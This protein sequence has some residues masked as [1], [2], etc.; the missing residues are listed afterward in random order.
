MNYYDKQ[1]FDL[2]ENFKDK[3]FIQIYNH[4]FKKFQSFPLITQQS[5]EQFFKQFPYWGDLEIDCDN[6]E[7]LYL[8]AKTLKEHYK[9]Y[10][11]LYKNLADFKSQRVLYSI[12]SNFYN[13]ETTPLKEVTDKIHYFDL[14]LIND[15]EDKT[16]VDVGSYTGDTIKDLIKIYGENYKKIYCFEITPSTCKKLKENL[17]NLNNITIINKAVSEKQGYLYLEE[18]K[19]SSGNR[20][21]ESGEEKIESTTIDGEISEKIDYI[22]MDIEG[23]EQKA[24]AGCKNHIKK[25]K[26]NLLISVYH[27]NEDLYK[28]PKQISAFCKDYKFYLRYY[29]GPLYA[30]EIV[31]FAL[32]DKN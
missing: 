21:L 31:L 28:I 20:V 13:F 9:D 29:G 4:M 10:V 17:S 16:F 25:D 32:I 8:K 30:T 22:K 14:G 3:Q 18:N 27:N 26:P 15:M 12:L 1:F 24:L 2:I 7:F 19:E 11:W 23:A 6:Y 5:F